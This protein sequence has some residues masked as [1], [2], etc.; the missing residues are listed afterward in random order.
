[1]IRYSSETPK[2]H[3]QTEPQ[4][5][6]KRDKRRTYFVQGLDRLEM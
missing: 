5:D 2:S 4:T 6:S 1:V 3:M